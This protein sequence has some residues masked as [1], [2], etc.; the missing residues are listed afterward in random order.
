M[1]IPENWTTPYKAEMSNPGQAVGEHF[2]YHVKAGSLA[3]SAT[4]NK[5]AL[6]S[7]SAP[8]L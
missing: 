8:L 1:D 5:S 6:N 4:I 3:L 7:Y 2:R